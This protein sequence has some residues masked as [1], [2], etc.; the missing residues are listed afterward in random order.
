MTAKT[1]SAT[2]IVSHN[3]VSEY[4]VVTPSIESGRFRIEL[5]FTYIMLNDVAFGSLLDVHA[6]VAPGFDIV[7]VYPV[8]RGA[9][10]AIR[11]VFT[12][13][14]LGARGTQ[15]DRL[16]IFLGAWKFKVIDTAV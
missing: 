14:P 16:A 5:V 2:H 9:V 4:V 11:W 8:V 3:I 15:V 7:I 1:K 12:V 6:F 10:G 13:S